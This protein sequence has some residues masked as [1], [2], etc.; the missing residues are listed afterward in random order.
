[1]AEMKTERFV[2]RMTPEMKDKVQGAAERVDMTASEF[3][4]FVIAIVSD[5]VL[6]T[7]DETFYK[8]IE[9]RFRLIGRLFNAKFQAKKADE[10][11]KKFVE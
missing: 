6:A 10:E 7:A 4:R 2:I 8:D 9:E 3:T 5:A 1:M 11:F